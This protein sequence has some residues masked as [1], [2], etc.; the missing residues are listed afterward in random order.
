MLLCDLCVLKKTYFIEDLRGIDFNELQ[1]EI[2]FYLYQKD[3]I[4]FHARLGL[5]RV[6]KAPQGTENI[7]KKYY[8]P[9]ISFN[10]S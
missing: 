9:V 8:L 5:V 1:L 2:S 4:I 7:L 10:L 6:I 3:M